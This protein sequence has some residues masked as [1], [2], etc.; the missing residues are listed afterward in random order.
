MIVASRSSRSGFAIAAALALLAICAVLGVFF[1]KMF[2]L[3]QED[4][5]RDAGAEKAYQAARAG[6]E[7]GAYQSLSLGAC[8]NS[9]LAL[10]GFTEFTVQ[11]SCQRISTSEAG[12]ALNV[13]SWMAIACNASSC[14]GVANAGY[15]ERQARMSIVK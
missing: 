10:P 15:V 9:T 14:P 11:V 6:L 2:N 4:A 13:D 1:L 8:A 3:G 5:A 12:V 7:Y